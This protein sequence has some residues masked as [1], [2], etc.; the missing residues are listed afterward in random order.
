MAFDEF[1]Y[2]RVKEISQKYIELSRPPAHIRDKLDIGFRI[3][4]QSVILFEIRPDYRRPHIKIEPPIAKATYIK[5]K[6]LWK[7]FYFRS[8]MKW[9][10]YKP[11]L[12]VKRFE[13]FFVIVD[14]DEYYCFWG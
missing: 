11:N 4:D 12:F 1:T 3:E 2:N 5:S 9:H 6:G 14:K 13:E 7:I 10:G 8:D